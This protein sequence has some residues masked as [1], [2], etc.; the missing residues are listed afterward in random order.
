MLETWLQDAGYAV[1]LLKQR[2]V[3][4]A[5]AALSLGIGIGA[6]TTI[7]SIASAL[8]LR[9][10]PGL[11]EPGRLVDIGR[12]QGGSGFDSTSYPNYLDLRSRTTTLEGVFA[13]RIEPEPMSLTGNGEAERVYGSVV[14]ANYFSVLGTRPHLGRVLQDSDDAVEGGSPVVVI[15]RE[16]WERRF[17]ADP[18]TVGRD[19]RLNGSVFT[20]VGVAPAGFQGTTILRSDVW[21]PMAMLAQAV[22]RMSTSLFKSRRA[23]WLF[24]G[25]RL[26]AGV[27]LAQAN[28]EVASIGASLEREF[29]DDNRGKSFTVLRAAPVPGQVPVIAGFM[30]ILMALV[31]LVLL[32]ACVNVAGMML[33]RAAARRRE[34]AVRL[35]I[36][37]GRLRLVR[38]LLTETAVLFAAGCALGLLISRG[39]TALLLSVVPALPVPISL[40]IATDWRVIAFATGIS[41]LAAVLS[42]LVPALQAS[43]ADLVPALKSEDR[44]ASGAPSR[45]RSMF[46]V[47]QIALSLVLIVAAG[48]FLRALQRAAAIDPGFT[49]ASVD[50]VS[51][52]LSMAGYGPATGP[53]FM[54]ALIQRTAMLPGV[55]SVSA[56]NDLPLDGG[57]MSAGGITVPGVEPPA[58][59]TSH[60]ADWNVVEPGYFR[61]LEMPLA[62]GRDFS[63][64][65]TATSLRVAIVNESFARRFWPGRTAVGQQFT[66]AGNARVDRPITIVGVVRDAKV[67]SLGSRAEPFVYVPYTQLYMAQMSLLVKTRDGR[68]AVPEI[69]ALVRTMNADLP[70]NQTLPLSSVTALGLIPQRLAAAV[71]GSL[72]IVVLLLAAIGIYGVTSYAVTSRTRE[73]GIRIALGA[74]RGRVVRLVVRQAFTLAALGIAGG[75]LLAAA[76]AQLLESLLFG[77]RGRDPLTFAAGC[78]LFVVITAVACFVPARRAAGLDPMTALRNE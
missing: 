7:F 22:P 6:N 51:L 5:T 53:A 55:E 25:A 30:G 61:T 23:V 28:A 13:H 43:R 37:A 4:A 66:V 33:A 63:E 16:L 65:D 9:P 54:R 15:S 8:L 73:I 21:I 44:G 40:E 62:A 74:D 24:L 11:A 69:R 3:F 60:R 20:V 42:G 67:V 48:L 49:D 32:I 10:L 27:S 64:A 72:A 17:G 31:G 58:G 70:L 26:K 77:I 78:T 71:A 57:R 2:P 59:R 45:L 35:A 18:G 56:A 75:V 36:G 34:I 68:S 50:V 38:Q 46:V 12:T 19:V 52:D 41:L 39:L 14:S 76:G 47:G 1:R 29:P